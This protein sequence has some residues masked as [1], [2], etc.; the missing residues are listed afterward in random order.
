[1][2]GLDPRLDIDRK[3]LNR[4][5]QAVRIRVGDASSDF[6]LRNVAFDPA[7]IKVHRYRH[8]GCVRRFQRRK[9]M[10]V[11]PAERGR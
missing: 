11:R 2:M 8:E 10:V 3:I 1:M 7:A 9:R 5:Q 4:L 6:V